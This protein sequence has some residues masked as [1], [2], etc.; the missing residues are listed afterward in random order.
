[1]EH[2][3]VVH[4]KHQAR[5]CTLAHCDD[6]CIVLNEKHEK[7]IQQENLVMIKDLEKAEHKQIDIDIRIS[8][9]QQLVEDEN[10]NNPVEIVKHLLIVEYLFH[11]NHN[12][13]LIMGKHY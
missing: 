8:T 9:N 11:C 2:D 13:Q 12:Y 5:V 3:Q 7:L 1:M 10:P 4:D 6:E